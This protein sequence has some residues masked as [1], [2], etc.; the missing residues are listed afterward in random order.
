MLNPAYPVFEAL[1]LPCQ[2]I[3]SR[4]PT[5]RL[6]MYATSLAASQR[7]VMAEYNLLMDVYTARIFFGY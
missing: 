6:Y 2:R 7:Q 3:S 5:L 1:R 4:Q